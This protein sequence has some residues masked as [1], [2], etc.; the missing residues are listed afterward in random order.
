MRD[1]QRTTEPPEEGQ[2]LRQQHRALLGALKTAN[3]EL[4]DLAWTLSELEQQITAL[5]AE[6][7]TRQDS[8]VSRRIG[9]LRR[10]RSTLEDRVLRHM[11]RVDE[12]EG[13]IRRLRE[14]IGSV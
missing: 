14:Q 5:V 1:V 2:R 12:L 10:W 4:A 13:E 8:A 9:D 7:S 6:Q 3:A 11:L